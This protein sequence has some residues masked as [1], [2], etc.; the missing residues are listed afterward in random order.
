MDILI[1]NI[2]KDVNQRI[3]EN[4][5][6]RGLSKQDYLRNIITDFDLENKILERQQMLLEVIQNNSNNYDNIEKKLDAILKIMKG[7]M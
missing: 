6:K 1:R 4:A 3:N 7:D 2:P 5:K